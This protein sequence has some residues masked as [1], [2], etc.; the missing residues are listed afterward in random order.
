M[1]P[2]PFRDRIRTAW[3][4]LQGK[5]ESFK[6][7]ELNRL[8]LEWVAACL[9]ADEELRGSLSK[10]RARAREVARN[11]GYIRQYLNLL[12][13]NVIGEAGFKLQALVRDGAGELI[14]PVNSA[15]EA[16]WNSWA[17]GAVSSDGRISLVPMERLLLRSIAR[18]GEILVR[19]IRDPA[20][21]RFGLALEPID[22]DLLDETYNRQASQGVN[23]IRLGVEVDQA[24]R[25]VGYW[26][27][28]APLSGAGSANRKRVFFPAADIL[29]IFDPDRV[30]QTRGLSWMHPILAPL[31]MLGGYEEA[32]LVA[33]RIS[34]AKMGWIQSKEG[35]MAGDI[36]ATKLPAEMQ[37]TPGSMEQLPP[38][39]EFVGWDPQH[40]SAAF[41]VFVKAQLR[42][43]ASGLGVSYNGLASDLEGVNYSS[44]RSGLLIERDTWRSLQTWWIDSFRRPIY[45]EFLNLAILTGGLAVSPADF[46][47]YLSC[48]WIPR[49]WAWVDPLKDGQATILGIKNGL[50][51]RTKALAEQGLDFEEILEDLKEEAELAALEGVKISAPLPAA[52]AAGAGAG[53]EEGAGSDYLGR[54]PGRWIQLRGGKRKEREGERPGAPGPL[55][56]SGF[57]VRSPREIG[58]RLP[59]IPGGSR[60]EKPRTPPAGPG[61]LLRPGPLPLLPRAG[62]R[63][64]S[65]DRGSRGRRS[66]SLHL[67][68]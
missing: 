59:G 6:A 60:N 1:R 20:V 11:D 36:A 38:G 24:G 2:T 37:A 13:N 9:P 40:P 33:A 10:I 64:G 49:G 3:R 53:Q 67:Q 17:Q 5:R 42:K 12:S 62:R 30:N 55:P 39:L 44:M 54:R 4:A 21:N 43:I 65:A 41:P 26:I 47:L 48:R 8:T 51:S 19:I 58:S 18:D 57:E 31:K 45:S 35:S 22:P 28:N 52:P 15:V 50:G 29:H 66:R 32:E 34:A 7:G 14:P 56:D 25:R 27:W 23:E 68:V 16:A 63:H 61:P 46:R